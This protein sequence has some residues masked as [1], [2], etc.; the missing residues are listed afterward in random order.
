MATLIIIT[1]FIEDYEKDDPLKRTID[2]SEFAKQF[3]GDDNGK[4]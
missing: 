2:M 3:G 1:R 4:V